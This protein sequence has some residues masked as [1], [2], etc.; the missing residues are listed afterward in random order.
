MSRRKLVNAETEGPEAVYTIGPDQHVAVSFYRNGIIHHFLVPAICEVALMAGAKATSTDAVEAFWDTAFELRD[1]LKFDFFFLEK[2]Q[3]RISLEEYLDRVDPQW[4]SRVAEGVGAVTQLLG[5]LDPITAESV[6]RS[7]LESYWI[8]AH[9]LQLRPQ[10]AEESPRDFVKFCA[11]TARQYL[12]QRRLQSSETGSLLFYPAGIELARNRGLMG[13]P[14]PERQE[15]RDHFAAKLR[16]LLDQIDEIQDI[17][18][19]AFNARLS[20]DA[21]TGNN[22]AN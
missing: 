14:G 15:A 21:N 3:Y 7:F 16:H 9:C 18:R 17:G 4:Q 20:E 2:N 10:Q 1:L 19:R 6:L 5:S 22:P 8:V 13:S 12:L 11:G